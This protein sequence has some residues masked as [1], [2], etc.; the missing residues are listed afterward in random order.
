MGR[1]AYTLLEHN[2]LDELRLSV[3]PVILGSG[4]PADLIF[5]EATKQPMNLVDTKV[6]GG[7]VNL[8]YQPAATVRLDGWPHQARAAR[9]GRRTSHTRPMRRRRP[10]STTRGVIQTETSAE[11]LLIRLRGEESDAGLAVVEMVLDPGGSG[12]PLHV[13]PTHG[14]GFYVLAGELTLQIGDEIVSGG[15]GT[16]AFA[17]KDTPHTLANLSG[18]EARL[19]CVFAPAGFERRFERMIA[20]QT[21]QQPPA[22][23]STAERETRAVGP[24]IAARA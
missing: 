18:Q 9:S 1:L 13:H 21:G 15:P 23:L 2:L 24:P 14:E 6:L 10:M 11:P 7:V 22:E 5:R 3:K 4:T 20:E 12:P 19:L 16:W 8:T 17:P